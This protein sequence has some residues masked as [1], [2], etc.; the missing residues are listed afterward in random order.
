M[1]EKVRT[2]LV[3]LSSLLVPAILSGQAR[4]ERLHRDDPLY[5]QHQ[6][7]VAEYHEAHRRGWDIP[8]LNILSYTPRNG[9]TFFSIAARLT[10]PYGSIAT[11]NRINHPS[12]PGGQDKTILVPSQPGLFTHPSPRDELEQAL[13]QRLGHGS[14]RLS[15]QLPGETGKTIQFHRGAD[16]SPA[17][18]ALFLRVRF[19]DPLPEGMIS[20]R[21]GYRV[22]P[23]TGTRSFHRGL[24]LSAPFGTPVVSAAAGIVSEIRR[25]PLLGLSVHVDHGNGYATVYAHLQEAIVR[26]GDT[27]A[28]GEAIGKVGSTGFSTGPH[29]HFEILLDGVNKD[30]ER[31]IR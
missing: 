1:K 10:L 23:M 16:F 6:Q 13:T 5:Q 25:D 30:P 7:M 15:L 24:D 11:L 17:E 4:I 19:V 9:D 27:L 20:S 18:R 21:Y 14:E 31:Y 3:L 8:P 28:Q 12:L 26:V 2:L 29:L 22:H